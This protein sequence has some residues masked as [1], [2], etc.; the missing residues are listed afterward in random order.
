MIGA[1]LPDAAIT[2]ALHDRALEQN[3]QRRRLTRHPAR[4]PSLLFPHCFRDDLRLGLESMS[5]VCH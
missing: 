4:G 3:A 5:H 1:K 2:I